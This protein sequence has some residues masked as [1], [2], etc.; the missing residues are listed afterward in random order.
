MIVGSVAATAAAAV[1]S[2]HRVRLSS[3]EEGSSGVKPKTRQLHEGRA[4]SIIMRRPTPA[5]DP[6]FSTVVPVAVSLSPSPPQLPVSFRPR[7]F[8]SLSVSHRTYPRPPANYKLIVP[9]FDSGDAFFSMTYE[10]SQ[11]THTHAH[12]VHM[13]TYVRPAATIAPT[14]LR[15]KHF[16]MVVR[17]QTQCTSRNKIFRHRDGAIPSGR[18]MGS[19]RNEI[20]NRTIFL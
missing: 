17:L 11:N 4:N 16:L 18:S 13:I 6:F 15:A 20:S 8:L 2:G 19:G 5:A 10:F 12:T 3:Q 9:N 1:S 14:V 7:P